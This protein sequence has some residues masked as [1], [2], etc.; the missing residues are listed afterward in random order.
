M[1]VVVAMVVMVAERACGEVAVTPGD[2]DSDV[3]A[4]GG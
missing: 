4:R 3:V 2:G 1:M